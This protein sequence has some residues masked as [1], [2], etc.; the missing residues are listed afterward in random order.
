MDKLVVMGP[1]RKLV[2][3]QHKFVPEKEMQRL[4]EHLLIAWPLMSA[5]ELADGYSALSIDLN[6]KGAPLTAHDCFSLAISIRV[7]TSGVQGCII[8]LLLIAQSIRGNSCGI[9]I[10]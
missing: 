1:T 10:K 4:Q 3:L 2:Q 8:C 5:A 7:H 6:S 9:G